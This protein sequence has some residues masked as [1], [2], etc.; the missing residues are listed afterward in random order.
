MLQQINL[1][2]TKTSV[3]DGTNKSYKL[4]DNLFF[5]PFVLIKNYKKDKQKEDTFRLSY[6]SSINLI[7]SNHLEIIYDDE[8]FKIVNEK[9]CGFLLSWEEIENLK[10]LNKINPDKDEKSADL[11]T[12]FLEQHCEE[13]LN[14]LINKKYYNFDDKFYSYNN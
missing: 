2:K 5:K 4:S 11:F 8:G 9:E 1:S 10:T 14:N 13:A 7:N 3:F 6:V 12:S